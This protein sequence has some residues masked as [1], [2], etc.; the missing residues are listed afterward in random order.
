MTF[1][2]TLKQTLFGKSLRV[3]FEDLLVQEEARKQKEAIQTTATEAVEEV[4]KDIVVA[5][6]TKP[7]AKPAAKPAKP[8]KNAKPA[9]KPAGKKKK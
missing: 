3:Q 9:A 7:A 8:A 1:W 4:V 5:K 2:E 6:K